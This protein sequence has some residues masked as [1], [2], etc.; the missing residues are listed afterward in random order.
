[1]KEVAKVLLSGLIFQQ[2][3]KYLWTV[4]STAWIDTVGIK[5]ITT[6]GINPVLIQT[7][8]VSYSTQKAASQNVTILNIE[9]WKFTFKWLLLLIKQHLILQSI[10]RLSRQDL[11]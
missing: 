8:Y 6:G 4:S 10:A 11:V 1:M 3:T 5:Q 9:T 2:G 7:Y